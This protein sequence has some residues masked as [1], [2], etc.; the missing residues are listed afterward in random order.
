MSI[1]V[2]LT[3]AVASQSHNR[4]A[5]ARN[6]VNITQMK[7][8]RVGHW[9]QRNLLMKEQDGL[10]FWCGVE[11]TPTL[12]ARKHGDPEYPL[13]MCTLD[14]M[15]DRLDPR[16]LHSKARPNER[17]RVAAC[18][19]CNLKRQLCG[20][21]K[22]RKKPYAERRPHSGVTPNSEPACREGETADV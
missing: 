22:W 7:A 17:R 8:T 9:R 13:T 14:H 6:Y 10:C 2:N 20:S 3:I 4:N 19:K 15:Y 11:M 18:L 1:F 12:P 5:D 21:A 16:R